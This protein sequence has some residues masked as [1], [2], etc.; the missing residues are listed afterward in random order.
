MQ[1]ALAAIVVFA[2]IMGAMA[3]GVIFSNKSLRGSCGG[4]GEGCGCSAAK[5][6]ECAAS[7]SSPQ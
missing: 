3:I 6:R 5:R 7:G 4:T 1:T 2:V